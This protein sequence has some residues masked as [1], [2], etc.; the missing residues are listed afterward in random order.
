MFQG[1]SERISKE[2]VGLVPAENKVKVYAPAE[3]KF[4]VWI[5]GSML[6]TLSTFKDQWITKMDYQEYG[7]NIVH[8]K[9][10]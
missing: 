4:S 5:G 2:I 6:S 1:I 10:P 8:K 3:R 7:T 9:C